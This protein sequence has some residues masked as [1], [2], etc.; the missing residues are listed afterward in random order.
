MMSQVQLKTNVKLLIICLYYRPSKK[1]KRPVTKKD[2]TDVTSTD[3]DMD[4]VI[5]T[6]SSSSLESTP[7]KQQRAEKGT[8]RHKK[9]TIFI[10]SLP[11]YKKNIRYSLLGPT[12]KST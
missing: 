6:L 7:V 8:G 9:V 2:K 5:F 1:R 12:W 4:D 10:L 3:D 11:K